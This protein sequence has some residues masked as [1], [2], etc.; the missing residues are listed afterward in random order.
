ME[1]EKEKAVN[2]KKIV[3]F[4]MTLLNGFIDKIS[5]NLIFNAKK[6]IK[7]A[8]YQVKKGIFAGLFLVAGVLLLI[9]GLAV[10]VNS[11]F[12]FIPGGGY[13]VIG[14]LSVLT[15]FVITLLIKK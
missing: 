15:A 7:E 6:Q 14:G 13:F 11:I 8:V 1:E 2:Y 9:I 10:Y 3:N 5:I 12:S 4:L